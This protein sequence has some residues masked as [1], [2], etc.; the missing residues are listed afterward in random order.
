MRRST[1]EGEGNTSIRNCQDVHTSVATLDLTRPK[2]LPTSLAF[3]QNFER[4]V[5]ILAFRC[6]RTGQDPIGRAYYVAD[7]RFV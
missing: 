5:S 2:Y 4:K 7:H 1:S 6:G 3:K